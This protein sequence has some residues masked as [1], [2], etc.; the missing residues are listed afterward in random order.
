MSADTGEI[1]EQKDVPPNKPTE[2]STTIVRANGSIP[3]GGIIAS[4]IVAKSPPTEI[5]NS[6]VTTVTKTDS[7]G[8]LLQTR[9]TTTRTTRTTTTVRRVCVV[10]PKDGA[11]I[12]LD[13]ATIASGQQGP[14]AICNLPKTGDTGVEVTGSPPENLPSDTQLGLFPLP[15]DK[16]FP[17]VRFAQFSDANAETTPTNVTQFAFMEPQT[18]TSEI[19]EVNIQQSL[20]LHVVFRTDVIIMRF[21][22]V[23][24]NT[25]LPMP[26]G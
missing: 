4:C 16:N 24:V 20:S 23:N 7:S 10:A 21:T 14:L 11:P 3:P 12:T 1:P 17:V 26:V 25:S 15:T 8:K 6:V 22:L 19:V 18:S 2:S 13:P 5:V 9:T